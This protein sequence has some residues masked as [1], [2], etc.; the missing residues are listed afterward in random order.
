MVQMK[1]LKKVTCFA[2][3]WLD[4]D[5]VIYFYE[6]HDGHENMVRA[7]YKLLNEADMVISYNGKTFDIPHLETEM[8]L[9]DPML[10]PSPYQHID[11]YQIVKRRFKF[12]SNKL[13]DVAKALGVGQKVSHSGFQLWIDC[14]NG[15]IEA[16]SKMRDYNK[17]DVVITEAVYLKIRAW[18]KNHPN[19]NV[20]DEEDEIEGCTRCSSFNYQR[21]G[22]YIT[23]F[24]I[25]QQFWCKDCGGWFT[26]KLSD[27]IT[28]HRS[29]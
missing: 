17:G 1:E 23:S 11:L 4:E 14:I 18:I 5:E 13:D 28:E 26:H 29:V 19:M 9:L 24:G 20:L 7:A 15:S 3:K 10:V 27:K 2:A 6:F 25:K 8:V 16:W 21:R 22:T 12:P